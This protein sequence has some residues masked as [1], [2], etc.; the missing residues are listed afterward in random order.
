MVEDHTLSLI[1][2]YKC[3]DTDCINLNNQCYPD[4]EDK[5]V[6]FNI[7]AVQPEKWANAI[8]TGNATLLVLPLKRY[9]YWK[10]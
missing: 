10:N 8:P 2:Q 1:N 5:S 6:H 7:T 9:I 3:T 4:P